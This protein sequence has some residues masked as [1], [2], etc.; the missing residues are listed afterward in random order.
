MAVCFFNKDYDNKHKYRCEYEISSDQIIVTVD[1]DI[2]EEVE[3]VDGIKSFGPNTKYANRDVLIIDYEKRTNYLLKDAYY[4]GSSFV[5]G[6]PDGGAKTKFATSIYFFCNDYES[7]ASL[8]ETPK[9]SSITIVSKDLL[10]Y[11]SESSVSRTEYEDKLVIDLNKKS[12]GETRQ[13]GINNIKKITLQEYWFGGFNKEHDIVFD[14]TGHLEI[15]LSR[16]A[17]YTEI[18]QYVYEVFVFLQIYTNRRFRIEDIKV[19]IDGVSYGMFFY[20]RN[21]EKPIKKTGVYEASVQSNIM[22]FLEKCYS[23]IPYRKSKSDIRN[24]PYIIMNSSRNIEDS[25]LIYYRFIKK[26]KKKQKIPNIVKEFIS[27]SLN[28]NYKNG[29]K[30]LPTEC[31]SLANEIISLRNHYVHS[32]YY[33]RNESLKIK[34][35]DAN[36]NYTVKADVEW[37]YERMNILYDCSVDI[38]FRNML[39]Y[40]NYN[41][42]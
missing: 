15:K 4:N 10:S 40:D 20:I 16:R 8:K 18:H 19:S 28:E 26:K 13:I 34:F 22:D 21:N 17:N 24:I 23:N 3:A 38:I 27:Y 31:D 25:I 29:R 36:K 6:T 1:Y 39:G 7:L 42:S 5:Y 32:G 2:S 30:S 9:V 12:Y 33:I 11:I 41:F 35:D 37:I 14:T